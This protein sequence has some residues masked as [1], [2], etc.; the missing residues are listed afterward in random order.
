MNKT[1]GATS[2]SSWKPTA[3]VT[4][5]SAEV[6]SDTIEAAEGG[7]CLKINKLYIAALI[8]LFSLG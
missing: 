1:H 2:L 3:T 7:V 4:L 8:L 6:N 5:G